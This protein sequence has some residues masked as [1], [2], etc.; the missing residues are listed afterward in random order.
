MHWRLYVDYL[1]VSEVNFFQASH[2]EHF[3][4][5]P[6]CLTSKFHLNLSCGLWNFSFYHS[7]SILI[8]T[9]W[10]KLVDFYY[11]G[12][13]IHEVGSGG[14]YLLLLLCV[15][16]QT[17]ELHILSRMASS[18]DLNSVIST[19]LSGKKFQFL[20]HK[21]VEFWVCWQ[22]FSSLISDNDYQNAYPTILMRRG[23]TV[24][25]ARKLKE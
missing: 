5:T 1:W 3:N 24:S 18:C 7:I 20:F 19:F 10:L 17:I 8:S 2:W 6:Q 4:L 13:T 23:H 9:Q 11:T 15:P 16:F 22:S 21:V 12:F 14:R 25:K